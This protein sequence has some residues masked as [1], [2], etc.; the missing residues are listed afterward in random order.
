LRKSLS[1]E[2]TE[3]IIQMIKSEYNRG[4]KIPTESELADMFS[5]SRT[6]IRESIKRLCER[7]V[8]VVRHGS[9]T[10]VAQNTGAINDPLGLEFYSP[11]NLS[12]DLREVSYVIQPGLAAL[13]AKKATD[14]DIAALNE[15][16]KK[17]KALYQA[18]QEGR[19]KLERIRLCNTEFHACILRCCHNEVVNRLDNLFFEMVNPEEEL[20]AF[21]AKS[22]LY[23]HDIITSAIS[24]RD[25]EM[26]RNAMQL[27]FL[28]QFELA[29]KWHAEH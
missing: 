7:N 4:D 1:A 20:Y 15:I 18:F 5:V 11:E 12:N 10:Y 2:T 14:E 24:Q 6:T 8:L 28:E 9:G 17:Y 21:T 16:N 25:V 26:A 13:A 22:D 3:K 19:E 27:H 29:K 23:F